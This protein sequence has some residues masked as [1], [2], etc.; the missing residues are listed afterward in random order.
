MIFSAL[1][2]IVGLR[3]YLKFII[4]DRLIT[5]NKFIVMNIRMVNISVEPF[6]GLIVKA[7]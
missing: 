2:E 3:Y 6:T 4:N 5:L 1:L 7:D